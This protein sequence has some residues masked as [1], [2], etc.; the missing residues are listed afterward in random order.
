M[1]ATHRT[2]KRG[3]RRAT[4]ALVVALA[5]SLTVGATPAVAEGPETSSAPLQG[6]WLAGDFHVHTCFSHDVYCGPGDDN[7][8]LDEL[9]TLGSNTQMQFCSAAARGLDFLTVTDHNDV[10]SQSDPGFGACGVTGVPGYENSLRGH[11]QMLGAQVVYDNGDLSTQAVQDL[12]ARLRAD[13]GAF[14][15]N[16]PAEGSVDFPHDEDWKYGYDVLPDSVE[17]WNIS[18]LWQPPAPSGSSND[19]AIRYWE[20]WLDRG[21]RVAAT[22]GSDN[23]WLGTQGVQGVGQPTTWVFATEDSWQ[24]VIEAV[25]AGRT[26]I[27][28]QPPSLGGPRL[29]LEADGDRDGSYEAMV[30][31]AVAPGSPLRVR[32]VGAAGSFLRLVSNGGKELSD[33]VLVTGSDFEHRFQ[34]PA[35]STWMRAEIF[36]PDA[37]AE[38]AA[39]CDGSLGGETTYCRNHLLVRAMTSALYLR[40]ARRPT[41]IVY[42]GDTRARGETVYLAAQ[43]TSAGAPVEGRTVLFEIAGQTMRAQSDASG[44]ASTSATVPD[45]GPSQGIAV[46]FTGDDELLPSSTAATVHWGRKAGD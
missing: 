10:R 39:A 34:A 13:G 12:A 42:T 16:H 45:H 38:R 8:G 46:S 41:E 14:Q 23:H 43:L 9:Y 40:A 3:L 30:G 21:A 25:R 17:V 11:A 37:A 4:A 44:A 24:G 5:A 32:V 2:R 36:E 18:R 1:A 19:D 33:P 6:E 35:T 22:G 29:Y 31:D 20:G 28:D 15:A 26:F 7:T 27:S